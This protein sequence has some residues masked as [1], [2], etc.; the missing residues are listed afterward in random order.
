MTASRQAPPRTLKHS[1][2]TTQCATCAVSFTSM[3]NGQSQAIY[4]HR[5]QTGLVAAE[6]DPYS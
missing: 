4:V 2:I 6:R 5:A 3:H 1:P